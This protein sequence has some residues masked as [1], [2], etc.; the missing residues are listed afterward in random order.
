MADG[1]LSMVLEILSDA[2]GWWE[3]GTYCPHPILALK[4]SGKGSASSMA[5]VSI[6]PT[7]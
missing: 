7:S 3:V 4:S 5:S 6:F 2:G 1:W